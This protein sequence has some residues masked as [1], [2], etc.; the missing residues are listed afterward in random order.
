[1]SEE[2]KPKGKATSIELDEDFQPDNSEIKKAQ[3]LAREVSPLMLDLFEAREEKK[4]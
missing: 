3:R 4:L 1:M 2:T